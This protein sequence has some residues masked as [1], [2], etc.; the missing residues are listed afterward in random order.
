MFSSE[1]RACG[2]LYWTFIWDG[3]LVG[4]AGMDKPPEDT[5]LVPVICQGW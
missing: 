3:R 1:Y 2:L 5:E 4:A